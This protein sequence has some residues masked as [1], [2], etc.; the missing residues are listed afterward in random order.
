M[1]GGA[2]CVGWLVGWSTVAAVGLG[3]CAVEVEAEAV[4]R[5]GK[6]RMDWSEWSG[7]CGVCVS[8]RWLWCAVCVVCA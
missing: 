2:C 7:A 3:S 5:G 6:E 4:G 8:T 1:R